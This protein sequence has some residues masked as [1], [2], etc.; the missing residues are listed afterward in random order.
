MAN[1]NNR[2]SQP[3]VDSKSIVNQFIEMQQS[4]QYDTET[5]TRQTSTT[6]IVAVGKRIL[7]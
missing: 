1:N 7:H 4:S 5:S 2:N 6:N 3:L